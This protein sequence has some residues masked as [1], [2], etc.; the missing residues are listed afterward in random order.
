MAS[1]ADRWGHPGRAPRTRRATAIPAAHLRL[2]PPTTIRLECGARE[3]LV[4]EDLVGA[5]DDRVAP[6][7]LTGRQ[8]RIRGFHMRRLS[9]VLE[10]ERQVVPR[11]QVCR[12][13][14]PLLPILRRAPDENAA[15]EHHHRDRQTEAHWAPP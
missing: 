10:G 2:R 15:D 9:L 8:L 13:R 3:L 7:R 6:P 14:L 4:L 1:S 5:D 11:C 12:V